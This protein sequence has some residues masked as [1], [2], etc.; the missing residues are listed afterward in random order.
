MRI[1]VALLMM[2]GL[3]MAPGPA[4]SGTTAAQAQAPGHQVGY[5]KYSLTV[6]GRR[7]MLW[8]GEFHYFRG[9]IVTAAEH[10]DRALV[11][12]SVSA[13]CRPRPPQPGSI[14]PKCRG[15]GPSGA[16]LVSMS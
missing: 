11:W 5:D 3:V 10:R 7:I 4:A 12:I 13:S 16:R 9:G 2:L 1:L 14:R 6:D 8:S 15:G